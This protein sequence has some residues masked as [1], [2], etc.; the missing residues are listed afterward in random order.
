MYI[1]KQFISCDKARI[2]LG[3]LRDTIPRL[4]YLKTELQIVLP[5]SNLIHDFSLQRMMF[6]AQLLLLLSPS[7]ATLSLS[8]TKGKIKAM[9]FPLE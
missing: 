9:N 1:I 3:L 4:F 8:M 6:L 7:V 5:R 2:L